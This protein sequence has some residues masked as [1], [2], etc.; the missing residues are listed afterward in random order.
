MAISWAPL[1][2]ARLPFGMG[3][4][5]VVAHVSAGFMRSIPIQPLRLNPPPLIRRTDQPTNHGDRCIELA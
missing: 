4:G 5:V 3:G 1:P 2:C